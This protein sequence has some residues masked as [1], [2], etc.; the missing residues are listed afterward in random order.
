MAGAQQREHKVGQ[1]NVKLHAFEQ[2]AL[3]VLRI[4]VSICMLEDYTLSEHVLIKFEHTVI[5]SVSARAHRHTHI[6][7]HTQAHT[8]AHIH[9]YTHRF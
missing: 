1:Y 6:H 5:R 4:P 9:T 3:P 8:H 7:I 2:T